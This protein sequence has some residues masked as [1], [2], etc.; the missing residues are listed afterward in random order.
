MNCPK[1]A[2]TVYLGSNSLDLTLID[3]SQG[4]IGE[5]VTSVPTEFRRRQQHHSVK[6]TMEVDHP[7]QAETID[8]IKKSLASYRN[9]HLR[10]DVDEIDD[11]VKDAA[12]K[13]FSFLNS[14][15]KGHSEFNEDFLQ[16]SS[17]DGGKEVEKQLLYWLNELE[18]PEGWQTD[19]R[20]TTIEPVDYQSIMRQLH[21]SGLWVLTNRIRYEPF[22]M[23]QERRLIMN[24]SV[25]R[26][27]S[28]LSNGIVL[29]DLPGKQ[30]WRKP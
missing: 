29:A 14:L 20:T 24:H 30:P 27:A 28:V 15:F 23:V 2:L 17:F 12:E 11:V 3:Y 22:S 18:L 26:D 5:S 8:L 13:G 10:E 6:L 1:I 9:L 19:R 16:K 21:E 7:T 25:Y 4:N